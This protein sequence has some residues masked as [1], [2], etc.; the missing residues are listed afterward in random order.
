[1]KESHVTAE[2]VILNSME[3]KSIR[4]YYTPKSHEKPRVFQSECSLGLLNFTTVCVKG[5]KDYHH[6]DP[7]S[8][9]YLISSF[10]RQHSLIVNNTTNRPEPLR[11]RAGYR[12]NNKLIN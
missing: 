11:G 12:S 8:M 9:N 1:M 2:H 4:G 7:Q 6:K 3:L 10:V 5:R